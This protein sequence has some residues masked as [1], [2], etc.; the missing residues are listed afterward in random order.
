VI[1]IYVFYFTPH[2][3]LSLSLSIYIYIYIY[4]IV[5]CAG[6]IMLELAYG[7]HPYMLFG[8]DSSFMA[9]RECEYYIILY[10]SVVLYSNM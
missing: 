10:Y 5:R 1:I 3:S 4:I 7:H 8:Q 6:L 9:M 2:L